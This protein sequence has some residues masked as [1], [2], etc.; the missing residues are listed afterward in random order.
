MCKT[1]N[2]MI[3]PKLARLNNRANFIVQQYHFWKNDMSGDSWFSKNIISVFGNI[4]VK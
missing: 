2:D 4:I 3:F 1:H